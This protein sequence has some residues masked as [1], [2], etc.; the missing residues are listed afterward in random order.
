VQLVLFTVTLSLGEELGWRGYLLPRLPFLGSTRALLVTGLVWA[1][2]HLPPIFL[3]PLYHS[4]GNRWLTVPLFVATIVGGS[5]FFGY[6]RLWTGSV[7]PAVLAHSAHNGAWGHPRRLHRHHLTGGGRG[8]PGRRQRRTHS[9]RHGTRGRLAGSSFGAQGSAAGLG[10]KTRNHFEK[11]QIMLTSSTSP[12]AMPVNSGGSRSVALGWVDLLLT[13][14]CALVLGAAYRLTLLPEALAV[15]M[16]TAP[17]VA[18]ASRIWRARRGQLE[19]GF[20][21]H[22]FRRELTPFLLQCLNHWLF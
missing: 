4:D 11:E 6:L 13:L 18:V 19:S 8:V 5:F 2:W 14:V 12:P 3:T 9:A 1:A 17:L 21:R 10:T 20:R 15:L 7:W 22:P 16:L